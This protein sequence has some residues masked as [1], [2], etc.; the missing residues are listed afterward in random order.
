MNT[1]NK[2]TTTVCAG[3]GCQDPNGF[4]FGYVDPHT[5]TTTG[6]IS[7]DATNVTSDVIPTLLIQWFPVAWLH[8][9]SERLFLGWWEPPEL[10]PSK[11]DWQVIGDDKD[12]AYQHVNLKLYTYGEYNT[13]T[14]RPQDF[15]W[16][17]FTWIQPPF[18]L[19]Y[20]PPPPDYY[21]I[22]ID[23]D[24]LEVPEEA[25]DSNTTTTP[26]SYR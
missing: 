7:G 14:W 23:W 18:H 5:K 11:E 17:E 13:D 1:C 15:H 20:I 25:D 10:P 6:S 4:P 26:T 21:H 2:E 24:S 12:D 16:P 22:D 3:T 8:H 9:Q 19:F